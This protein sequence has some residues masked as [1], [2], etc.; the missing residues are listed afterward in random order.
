MAERRALELGAPDG[1]VARLFL[2]LKNSLF[3]RS[4]YRVFGLLPIVGLDSL[5]QRT[6]LLRHAILR[7]AF[8]LRNSSRRQSAFGVELTKGAPASLFEHA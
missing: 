5:F 4:Y 1:L 7:I 8:L 2:I 3:C 6:F